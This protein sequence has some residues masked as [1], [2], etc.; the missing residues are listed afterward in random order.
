MFLWVRKQNRE[1]KGIDSLKR[2]LYSIRNLRKTKI[3][4]MKFM[5]V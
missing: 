3:K 2:F 1:N 4:E 5:P